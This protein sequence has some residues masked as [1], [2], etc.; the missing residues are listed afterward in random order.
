M[1]CI[2]ILYKFIELKT[3]NNFRCLWN[4]KFFLFFELWH[5]ELVNE[6][7]IDG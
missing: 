2:Y 5:K 3:K 1:L 4:N 6:I 7:S